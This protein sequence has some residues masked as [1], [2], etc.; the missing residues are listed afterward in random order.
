MKALRM[1]DARAKILF[2]A[3]FM[4]VSLHAHSLPPLA[5]CLGVALVLAMAVRLEP[6][7]VAAVLLPLVP[8]LAFTVVMQALSIQ[9]GAPLFQIGGFKLTEA[10]AAESLRMVACLLALVLAS[11][12]FMRC[13]SLEDLLALLDGMFAPVRALGIRTDGFTL[14][15]SV[16]LGFAPVLVREFHQLR[17]AQQA[18]AASFDGSLAAR[19]KAYTR[20]LP[21]LFHS[22]FVHADTLAAAFLARGF[23][24]GASPTRLHPAHFGAP[25]AV[26]LAVT[27]LMAALAFV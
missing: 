16:A 25:E 26:C 3:V 9:E 7:M 19:L 12:S 23:S 1:L 2:L 11:V 22:A 8:I 5:V 14:A 10:A 17:L 27:A 21:P 20:L 15:L 24:C 6:R 4:L 18:R 13:T